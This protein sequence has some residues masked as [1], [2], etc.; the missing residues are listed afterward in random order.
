[1]SLNVPDRQAVW[2]FLGFLDRRQKEIQPVML[3]LSSDSL[4]EATGKR[5]GLLL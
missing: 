4:D 1:M 2:M 3:S 5:Q